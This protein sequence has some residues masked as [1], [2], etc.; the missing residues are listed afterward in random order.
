MPLPVP[1]TSRCSTG[2][3]S[4]CGHCHRSLEMVPV[5]AG[6]RVSLARGDTVVRI[7]AN[8]HPIIRIGTSQLVMVSAPSLNLS[9]PIGIWHLKEAGL[10]FR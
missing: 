4:G 9:D 3:R 7:A 8:G 5:D 1:S 6:R 10:H 2:A